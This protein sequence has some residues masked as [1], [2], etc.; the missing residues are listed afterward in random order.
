MLQSN[1]EVCSDELFFDDISIATERILEDESK[2]SSSYREFEEKG[3]SNIEEALALNNRDKHDEALSLLRKGVIATNFKNVKVR[4]FLAKQYILVMKKD[5]TSRENKD[6]ASNLQSHITFVEAF[7][8]SDECDEAD[9]KYYTSGLEALKDHQAGLLNLDR[10]SSNDKFSFNSLTAAASKAYDRWPGAPGKCYPVSVL[11]AKNN[12]SNGDGWSWVETKAYRW[13]S[14]EKIEDA[15]VDKSL[16]PGMVIYVNTSPGADP[17]SLNMK[18]LPHWF[19]YLGKD[20]KGVDRFSDQ[21]T[22]NST[23]QE[24]IK[25]VPGRLVDSFFDPYQ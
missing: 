11:T 4:Y 8:S 22:F 9:K 1:F 10:S 23:L 21:Y 5:K 12:G 24:M 7:L 16:K 17:A 6:F 13:K 3:D 15:I 20:S 2:R 25:F 19:T 18:Y 14:M